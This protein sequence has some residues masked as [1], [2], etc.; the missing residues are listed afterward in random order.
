MA[1]DPNK[2]FE[3]TTGGMQLPLD[4]SLLSSYGW[5]SF[6]QAII[7][8]QRPLPDTLYAEQTAKFPE[9]DTSN[10]LFLVD[11]S[12]MPLEWWEVVDT[13]DG[14]RGMVVNNSTLK[15]YAT[16]WIDFD[17]D[18]RTGLLRIGYD[19]VYSSSTPTTIRVYPPNTINNPVGVNDPFGQYNCYKV[20]NTLTHCP[21]GGDGDRTINQIPFT[22]FNGVINGGIDGKI[23][24]ATLYNGTSQ[25]NTAS[26]S[27]KDAPLTFMAWNRADS[28]DDNTIISMANLDE[29]DVFMELFHNDDGTYGTYIDDSI[30][31]DSVIGTQSIF[32]S[33]DW[34]HNVSVFRNLTDLEIW[35]NGILD[36]SKT[37][38]SVNPTIN[39]ISI[40]ATVSEFFNWPFLGGIE[41][42]FVFTDVKS[43]DWIKCEYDAVNDNAAFWGGW[44]IRQKKFNFCERAI[45][46]LIEQF[47]QKENIQKYLCALITPFDELREVLNDLQFNRNLNNA[48]GV[49]LDGIGDIVGL[50]RGGLS[51]SE[52]RTQI[53]IKILVNASNG[54]T[55]SVIAAMLVFAGGTFAN[56][57]D[58]FPARIVI[59]SDGNI[60]T[61]I[62]K[63]LEQ[64]V[65]AGVK[66]EVS[67][68][69]GERIAFAFRGDPGEPEDPLPEGFSEPN[70]APDAGLGGS[71]TEKFS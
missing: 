56:V 53:K 43:A 60:P 20:A 66:I 44:L 47:E 13:T 6:D 49:Q 18:S 23:G 30:N 26:I 8:D 1:L 27:D 16:D 67:A 11:L 35:F 55:E 69:Y 3:I 51:D 28:G 37:G 64:V 5:S 38:L 52:Y 50:A 33:D 59:E 39:N 58:A 71:L 41:Q 12:L 10:F 14:T 61:N 2:A 36:N 54:E 24:K 48:E 9:N 46:R 70:Y 45:T 57:I 34:F 4:P 40:G 25:Y 32:A 29:S 68:T 31:S 22:P 17:K 62:I 21:N 42:V 65:Q 19:D 63:L 7:P 15:E